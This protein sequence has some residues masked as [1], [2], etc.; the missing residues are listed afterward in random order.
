MARLCP[1]HIALVFPTSR[2]VYSNARKLLFKPRLPVHIW[3]LKHAVS[4][5]GF[6]PVFA[7]VFRL[8]T[9]S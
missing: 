7:S 3:Q 5:K 1:L 9:N 8:K 6:S 2:S 4:L